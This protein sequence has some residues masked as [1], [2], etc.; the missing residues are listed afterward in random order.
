M[1]MK[2]IASTLGLTLS[3]SALSVS[4]ALAEE[5][6][7]QGSTETEAASKEMKKEHFSLETIT[8]TARKIEEN[9]QE[10]PISISS[11]SAAS[12]EDRQITDSSQL[13]QVVPNL[14]FDTNAPASGSNSAGQIFIRGVGQTD[15]QALNDP[16]VGVYIDG[17]YYA[18]TVGSV[19]GLLDLDK[20]EVLRGPQ[21]TLFG[22]NTIGG[23]I[24]IKTRRPELDETFGYFKGTLGTDNL[25]D[26]L[27]SANIPLGDTVAATVTLS[28][29]KQDGY[30][31]KNIDGIDLGDNNSKYLRTRLYWEASDKFNVDFIADYTK[32]DENGQPL[33]FSRVNTAS[34]FPKFASID[35]GCVS[36][37]AVVPENNDPNCANNQFASNGKYS[38]DQN[39]DTFSKLTHWG[40]S[41]SM[42]WELDAFNFKSITSYRKLEAFAAR[43]ADNTP[44]TIIHSTFSTDD[45]QFSQEFQLTGTALDDKLNWLTGLYYFNQK[46]ADENNVSL[47]TRTGATSLAGPVEITSTALFAQGTYALTENLSLTAGIRYTDENKSFNPRAKVASDQ[48]ILALPDAQV[49][50]EYVALLNSLA[51][52]GAP[53]SVIDIPP[54]IS[55]VFLSKGTFLLPTDEVESNAEKVTSL[56]NLSYIKDNSLL[57][58]TY[59]EGFKGG[60]VNF[61]VVAPEF[62]PVA[63]GPETV[64]QYEVGYKIDL[65]DNNLRLNTSVFYSDYEDIQVVVTP[66]LT[67]TTINAAKGNIKGLEFEFTAVPTPDMLING[68]LGYIETE[69]T[70]LSEEVKEFS[71]LDI[72]NQFQQT[73]KLSANLGISYAFY[74]GDLTIVPRIDWSYKDKRYFDAVNTEAISQDSFS[75]MNIGVFFGINDN[76]S[77]NLLV[78]NVTDE[79]YKVA[80]FSS[81]GSAAGYEEIAYNRGREWFLSLKY[82]F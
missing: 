15:F 67:P 14:T 52:A 28:S 12:L 27:L 7:K 41:L 62:E 36:V 75:T 18:R 46:A 22:R 37:G 81:Y 8:V 72:D 55:L 47:P 80:G 26:F 64:S 19:V 39:G 31:T 32:E 71:N 11:F 59:S 58:A 29:Q 10:T 25:N 51:P 48:L 1:S 6:S 65:L 82:E 77:A 40:A 20:V 35:A 44:L 24:D 50:P 49:T 3:I 74:P 43:D 56:V 53:P 69:Y 4:V 70:K 78:K 21:G 16:G 34:S 17:V 13:S 73:P 61:R 2:H 66:V 79:S 9:L 38:T 57:Y 23:A 5:A 42:N 54:P 33:V 30:V 60:G 76:L 45:K 68:S 63:F